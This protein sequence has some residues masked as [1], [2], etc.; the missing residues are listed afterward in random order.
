[1]IINGVPPAYLS[2]QTRSTPRSEQAGSAP[3][4]PPATAPGA[5]QVGAAPLSGLNILSRVQTTLPDGRTLAV[6]RFDLGTG[7]L[8]DAADGSGAA[9]SPANPTPEDRRDD[10][11]MLQ[12][13]MQIAG[14]FAYKPGAADIELEGTAAI[15]LKA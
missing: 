11:E 4:D 8:G 3:A 9:V 5:G 12:A 14:N 13:L 15:D 6:F 1:M 7:G 10:N 2:A